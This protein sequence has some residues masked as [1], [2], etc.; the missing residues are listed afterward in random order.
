MWEKGLDGI[1]KRH[2]DWV[3]IEG[4]NRT[5]VTSG[6]T[7]Q[8][9]HF[10]FSSLTTNIYVCI[11]H[12]DRHLHG[13]AYRVQRQNQ[14][15]NCNLLYNLHMYQKDERT[16]PS[17]LWRHKVSRSHVIYGRTECLSLT[18]SFTKTPSVILL[19]FLIQLFRKFEVGFV[20]NVDSYCE[21]ANIM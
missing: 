16:V 2:T 6:T 5:A 13:L 15:L 9:S 8:T 21:T 10:T 4:C 19:L 14:I 17:I 18:T 11:Y 3:V 1:V 12:I 7:P 20:I